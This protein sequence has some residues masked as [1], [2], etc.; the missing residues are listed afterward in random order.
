VIK[1]DELLLNDIERR[2][3]DSKNLSDQEEILQILQ[4]HIPS[5]VE[6]RENVN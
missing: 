4:R 2:L 1:T 5:S 3:T 6:L